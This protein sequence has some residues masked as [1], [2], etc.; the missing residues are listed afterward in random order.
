M[1]EIFK[2]DEKGYLRW[3]AENPRGFIVNADD[4]ATSPDYPMVHRA[5]HKAMTSPR[6]G[7]YTTGRYFKVCSN[8][9][10]EL[11]DWAKA[12]RKRQLSPCGVCM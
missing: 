4:P 5:T 2:N 1:P 11:E 6:R 9:M 8:D 12:E 10:S 7:N 3:V